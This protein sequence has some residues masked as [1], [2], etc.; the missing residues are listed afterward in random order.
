MQRDVELYGDGAKLGETKVE[1]R[2]HSAKADYD[3]ADWRLVM[4]SWRDLLDRIAGESE[5]EDGVLQDLRQLKGIT[6]RMDTEAFKPLT[7]TDLDQET[8]RRLLALQHLVNNVV[9]LGS[10][11]GL[12]ERRGVQGNGHHGRLRP[13][14]QVRALRG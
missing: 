8:P 4:V 7:E 11:E 5:D 3:G 6:E 10:A 9:V 2:I 13:V 1:G 14:L 12:A